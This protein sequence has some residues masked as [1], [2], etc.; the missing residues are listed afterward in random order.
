MG[1]DDQ[2][3]LSTA[4]REF[5]RDHGGVPDLSSARARH[6][7]ERQARITESEERADYATSLTIE[8][9]AQHLG[10][11]ARQIVDRVRDRSLAART[12]GAE[13]RLPL[14][15][16]MSNGVLPQLRQ[17]LRALPAD[18]HPLT[19]EGFMTTANDELGGMSAAEWLASG[20]DVDVVVGCASTLTDW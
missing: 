19:V 3:E 9:A 2:S 12:F 4:E 17:V 11:S 16:F 7:L 14:W 13:Q 6:L 5:L 10:L 18:A 1:P 20:G 8:E 15:Q